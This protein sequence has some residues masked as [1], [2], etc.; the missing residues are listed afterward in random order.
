MSH[1]PLVLFLSEQF[2]FYPFPGSVSLLGKCGFTW[3]YHHTEPFQVTKP[4][5]KPIF[6]GSLLVGVSG[7]DK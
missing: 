2:S 5:D 3:L 1:S 7:Q 6:S 4:F